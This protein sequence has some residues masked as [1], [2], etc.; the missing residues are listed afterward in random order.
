MRVNVIYDLTNPTD[1][2]A[3]KCSQR[4][5]EAF[6]MLESLQDSIDLYMGKKT[7]PEAC[8]VDLYDTLL[9]WKKSNHVS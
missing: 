3:Y 7:T 8:L 2:H 9:R 1:A 4:A 6:Y 5:V